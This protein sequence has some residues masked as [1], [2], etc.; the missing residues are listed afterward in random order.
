[1]PR[2]G[3]ADLA[4]G[5]E[6][7]LYSPATGFSATVKVIFA[8][9]TQA[10]IRVRV[11][12]RVG[13]GPTLPEDFLDFDEILEGNESRHSEYVDMG[14]TEELLAQANAG[15]MSVQADGIEVGP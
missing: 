15:G 9:R 13:S 12:R 3:A 14:D 5:V 10:P 6:T 4:A 1:M 8:N 7:F 11:I 2:L